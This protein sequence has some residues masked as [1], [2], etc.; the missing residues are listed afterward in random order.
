MQ[1]QTVEVIQQYILNT[2][3]YVKVRQARSKPQNSPNSPNS[4]KARQRKSHTGKDKNKNKTGIH[5]VHEEQKA[6]TQS[7]TMTNWQKL[8]TA[9]DYIQTRHRCN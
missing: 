4:E 1:T 5:T 8:N 6:G 2:K 3:A 9:Q 7:T